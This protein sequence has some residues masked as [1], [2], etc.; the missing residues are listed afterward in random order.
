MIKLKLSSALIGLSLWCSNAI[1]STTV[2]VLELGKGGTVR[3]TTSSNNDDVTVTSVS[4][5]WS[6]LHNGVEVPS[7]SRSL[8]SQTGMSMVP[9]IFQRPDGGIVVGFSGAKTEAIS[10]KIVGKVGKHIGDFTLSGSKGNMLMSKAS[11]SFEKIEEAKDLR[12]KEDFNTVKDNK[13][14]VLS[15]DSLKD[16]KQAKEFVAELI[17]VLKQIE[18]SV[19]DSGSTVVVY[20]ISEERNVKG[21]NRS[22]HRVLEE[23]NDDANQYQA[24]G[25]YNDYGEWITSYKTIFQIQYYNIVLWTSIGLILV[26]YVSN[27]MLMYMPLMEDTLLFGETAKSASQ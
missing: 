10:K 12:T 5:F 23:E 3:R 9:D 26:L 27:H 7:K 20:L 8:Q 6:S 25:Y 22:H 16:E 19:N 1:D 24:Y 17:K 18:S 21:K 11:P 14:H 4:S 15:L 13:L 2:T